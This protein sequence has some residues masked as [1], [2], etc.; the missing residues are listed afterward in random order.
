MLW[1]DSSGGSE[2]ELG[3]AECMRE[4]QPQ[5]GEQDK[6]GRTQHSSKELADSNSWRGEV[7]NQGQLTGEQVL[8]CDG[9]SW[10]TWPA[11]PEQPQHEWE[12]PRV[13]GDT[14]NESSD[15]G[16]HNTKYS[17]SWDGK[18]GRTAGQPSNW[19][20][21]EPELGRATNG[22]SSRVDR[23]R[24]LGNGVVPATAAKAFVTLLQRLA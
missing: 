15:V 12:E 18:S 13:V 2:E 24:L 22:A 1:Q 14:S 7:Q 9:G 16:N 11:R 3:N 10:G 8:E 4:S 21:A 5:G 19:D 23:L 17:N 20:E 6:R